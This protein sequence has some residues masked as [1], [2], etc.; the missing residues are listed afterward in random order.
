MD[1]ERLRALIRGVPDFPQPGINF[2]DITTLLADA[3]GLRE[4]VQAVAAPFRD[5]GVDLVVGIESRGFIVGVP[6]AL[7]LGCGFVPVRKP[8]KL[9]AQ[10]VRQEYQLEYGTDAVEIHRDAVT[11]DQRVLLI[12]DLLATGGTMAA[13]CQLVE[14]LGAT[15]SG[16][17]FLVEL[18]FLHGRARLGQRRVEAVVQY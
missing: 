8:G 11:P 1:I 16:I 4:A 17:G 12:D 14:G 10:T 7:E 15:V 13:C 9:P 6:V 18:C 2:Y 3:D 5:T